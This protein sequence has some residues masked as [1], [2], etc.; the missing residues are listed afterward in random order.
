MLGEAIT[1]F[2]SW[3][4]SK[5]QGLCQEVYRPWAIADGIVGP[6]RAT[7][8]ATMGQFGSQNGLGMASVRG[9]HEEKRNLEIETHHPYV[10]RYIV[11]GP[12]FMEELM[13][14]LVIRLTWRAFSRLREKHPDL[15]FDV[16]KGRFLFCDDSVTLHLRPEALNSLTYTQIH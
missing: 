6:M 16:D 7:H 9:S 12:G 15:V 1:W 10:L 3:L 8:L 14:I 13:D 5:W 4:L 2:L 11:I